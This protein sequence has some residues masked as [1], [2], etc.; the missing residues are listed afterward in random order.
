MQLT[1][2]FKYIQEKKNVDN[3]ELCLKEIAF[4][5]KRIADQMS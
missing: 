4:Q 3:P 2:P 5:L 1:T